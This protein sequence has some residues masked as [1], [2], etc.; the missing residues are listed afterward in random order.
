MI[1][2]VELS[3]SKWKLRGHVEIAEVVKWLWLECK[4]KETH[5]RMLKRFKNEVLAIN[6]KRKY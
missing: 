3:V 6:L 5:S 1:E 4:G 2:S